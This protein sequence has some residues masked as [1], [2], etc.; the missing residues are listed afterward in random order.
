MRPEHS[1]SPV[2]K[3]QVWS[4]IINLEPTVKTEGLESADKQS[5]PVKFIGNGNFIFRY[6]ESLED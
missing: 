1:S 6:K 2:Q 5:E 3:I 4:T